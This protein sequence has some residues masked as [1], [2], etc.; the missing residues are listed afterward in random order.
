[1]FAAAISNDENIH[2]LKDVYALAPISVPPLQ[3]MKLITCLSFGALELAVNGVEVSRWAR[4]TA[5]VAQAE[6]S[7]R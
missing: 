3:G 7:N 5:D 2:D 4:K 1:M 6:R